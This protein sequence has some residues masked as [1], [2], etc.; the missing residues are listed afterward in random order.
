MSVGPHT[1][2][3]EL[4]MLKHDRADLSVNSEESMCEIINYKTV[5]R[6][7]IF[8]KIRQYIP[9]LT[10]KTYLDTANLF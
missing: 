1:K 8:N 10:N 3:F 9:D 2:F 4:L 5:T 6:D 7:S